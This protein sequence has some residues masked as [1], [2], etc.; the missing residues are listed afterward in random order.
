MLKA[1]IN[2]SLPRVDEIRLLGK[3]RP[4]VMFAIVLGGENLSYYGEHLVENLW[5]ACS[6]LSH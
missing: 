2:A 6:L 5:S 4:P 1:E 3:F